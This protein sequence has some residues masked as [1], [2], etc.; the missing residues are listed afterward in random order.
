[1]TL[2]AVAFGA[3]GATTYTGGNLSIGTGYAFWLGQS[4]NLTLNLDLSAQGYG[5]SGSGPKSSSMW[6]LG[7]G[8][9]W[10]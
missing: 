6:Q 2:S 7:V 4:F 3:A 8:F 9:D 5:G 1:M 10:Y